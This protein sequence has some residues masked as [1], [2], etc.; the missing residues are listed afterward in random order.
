MNWRIGIAAVAVVAVLGAVMGWRARQA[1]FVVGFWYEDFPLTFSDSVNAALGG[2][3]TEDDAHNIKRRSV[4]ELKHAFGGLKVRFIDTG[5]AFWTVRVRR[6]F[7]RRRMQLLPSAGQT[8]SLGRLGGRSEVNFTE[9]MLAAIAHAPPGATRQTLID[10]IGRGVGRTAVH[11]LTHAILGATAMDNRTD[12]H[13]YEFFTHNRP[14]WFYG[15]LHW[16][17]AWPVLVE[18]VG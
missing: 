3:L 17:N 8:L 2:P 7:E 15:P 13:S 16:A 1:V 5:D 4:E 10:G 11:E 18:R 14:A 12:E 6:S 9:V